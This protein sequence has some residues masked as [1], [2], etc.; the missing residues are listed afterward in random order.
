[1][2]NP[3][4]PSWY[5]NT[6]SKANEVTSIVSFGQ[7]DADTVSPNRTFFFWNNY[8]GLQDVA[9]MEDV[10]FTVRDR[11]GGLGDTVGQVME[12]VRDNWTEVRCDSLSESA[13]KAVGKG[14]SGTSNPSGV[15]PLGTTGSTKNVN[16]DTASAWT[17]TAPLSLDAYVKPTI[18]NGFIYKVVTAGTTGATEPSWL[19]TEGLLTEDDSVT[20]QAIPIDKTPEANQI[21]GLANNTL[22]DGSNASDAAGNFVE[23]TTRINAPLSAS[24]GRQ[25]GSYRVNT[26]SLI[27]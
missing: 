8:G 14:G 12:F 6:N 10:T 5:E 1:M 9:T 19:A 4:I 3:P 23:L 16:F 15:H 7:I 25:A 2:A 22:P 20:F 27:Q 24:S 26:C 21:L 18:D 17:A 11:N 13:F